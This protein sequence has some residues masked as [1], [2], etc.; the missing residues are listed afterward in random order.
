M[1]AALGAVL[2]ATKFATSDAPPR[3]MAHAPAAAMEEQQTATC[4][5]QQHSK[6][7]QVVGMATATKIFDILCRL[8]GVEELFNQVEQALLDTPEDD[9]ETEK[10]FSK[11]L[12]LL[13]DAPL[14]S[15][16]RIFDHCNYNGT[17]DKGADYCDTA[18][19]YDD[20]IY[21]LDVRRGHRCQ[22]SPCAGP[23]PLRYRGK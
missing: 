23:F 20:D 9:T 4:A 19:D 5:N 16:H 7:Q 17:K 2:G 6:D 12:N 3:A 14:S 8:G 21:L 1:L 11:L 22:E 13:A 10:E 18:D 15:T